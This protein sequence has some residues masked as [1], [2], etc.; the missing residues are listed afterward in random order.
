MKN[1]NNIRK[2][3]ATLANILIK[4]AT[5][6]QSEAWCW[7]WHIVREELSDCMVV[8]FIKKGGEVTQRV[9]DRNFAKHNPIK[10]TG[11]KAP[12]GLTLFADAAKIALNILTGKKA[13]T[14]ISCYEY[15]TV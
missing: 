6:T 12:E 9:V 7:A 2:S 11:R 13:S 10:G 15:E 14:A 8:R 4:K 1:L 5:L 3:V